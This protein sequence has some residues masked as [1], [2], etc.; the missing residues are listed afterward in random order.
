VVRCLKSTISLQEPFYHLDPP[1]AL[2]ASVHEFVKV[3]LD[4]SDETAKLAWITLSKVAWNFEATE[5]EEEAL[6][7]KYVELFMEHGL[8]RG[9]S[10][11]ELSPSV[12]LEHNDRP[13]CDD[14]AKSDNKYNYFKGYAKP[15]FN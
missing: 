4:I 13:R 7:Y 12:V 9:I 15:V 11:S 2:S 14:E 5:A 6:Q 10:T 8:S 3:C 1:E